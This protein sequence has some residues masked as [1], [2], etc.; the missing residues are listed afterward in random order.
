MQRLPPHSETLVTPACATCWRK[1]NLF[2]H[3]S[4]VVA[5]LADSSWHDSPIASR[6]LDDVANARSRPAEGAKRLTHRPVIQPLL[7]SAIISAMPPWGEDR[8]GSPVDMASIQVN[9]KFSQ[10]D[11]TT[12]IATPA[13][14]SKS[15][16]REQAPWNRKRLRSGRG[17]RA[18]RNA[19]TERPATPPRY[20]SAP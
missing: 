9:G 8:T 11:G 10:R 5:D 19:R 6:S 12:A 14:A 20:V 15:L 16:A 3:D 18:F 7:P 13:R 2:R 4:I 17:I 1:H